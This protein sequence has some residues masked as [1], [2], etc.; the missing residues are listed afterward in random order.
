MY[1]FY[2]YMYMYMICIYD[3]FFFINEEIVKNGVGE[4]TLQLN[5]QNIFYVLIVSEVFD[6][7]EIIA[8][9]QHFQGSK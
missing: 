5:K 2:M 9:Y 1:L 6:K 7:L 8:F 3:L 4:T